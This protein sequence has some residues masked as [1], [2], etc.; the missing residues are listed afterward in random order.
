M[1]LQHFFEVF[2]GPT[3]IISSIIIT[4]TLTWVKRKCRPDRVRGF[5]AGLLLWPAVVLMCFMVMHIGHNSYNAFVT[6][7]DGKAVFAFYHYGLVLFGG[8]VGTQAYFLAR[9]VLRHVRGNQRFSGR[10][11][12]N[13]LR[14]VAT[15]LPTWIFTVIGIIPTI[16]MT[17]A[18]LASLFTHRAAKK[19]AAPASEELLRAP[20]APVLG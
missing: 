6:I 20:A 15:T 16:L 4:I 8:T 19:A 7:R 1:T 13:I 9:Q 10:V 17:I 18:L 14:I 2:S 5:F 3:A 12:F 11:Y